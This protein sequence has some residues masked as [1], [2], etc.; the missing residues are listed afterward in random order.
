MRS[1]I[2]L[3][4]FGPNIQYI[5][6]VYNIVSDVLSGLPY[7]FSNKYGTVPR[8]QVIRNWQGRKQR[9]L[10]PTKYLNFAKRTTKITEEY[11]FQTQH[12]HLGLR[13]HLLHASSL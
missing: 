6:V 9:G 1:R 10:F 4:D 3:E 11:K 8:E 12:I 2:I 13:I 7:T 5:A